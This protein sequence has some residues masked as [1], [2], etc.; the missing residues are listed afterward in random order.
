[1]FFYHDF[2]SSTALACSLLMHYSSSTAFNYLSKTKTKYS[3][4]SV[5]KIRNEIIY[6]FINN[7]DLGSI[8][9][10]Q[11]QQFFKHAQDLFQGKQKR[12]SRRPQSVK[13]KPNGRLGTKRRTELVILLIGHF[14]FLSRERG[15]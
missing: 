10:N 13:N 2:H 1:M 9:A 4:L 3:F 12:I 5:Y 8:F 6:K 14:F 7:K 15:N 11:E